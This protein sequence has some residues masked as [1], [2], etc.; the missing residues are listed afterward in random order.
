MKKNQLFCIVFLVFTTL[1]CNNLI[2]AQILEI[3]IGGP[4]KTCRKTKETF[5]IDVPTTGV[6]YKWSVSDSTLLLSGIYG[7]STTILFDGTDS[8]VIISI[9]GRDSTGT[10]VAMGSRT[11]PVKGLP[12]PKILSTVRVGCERLN[13]STRA[14]DPSEPLFLDDGSCFKVCEYSR[15]AFQVSGKSGLQLSAAG[16]QGRQHRII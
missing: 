7:D 6:A 1:L 12:N 15:T 3:D 5:S 8:V 2:H 4:S 16:R 13:D 11:I 10:L 14:E 9:E